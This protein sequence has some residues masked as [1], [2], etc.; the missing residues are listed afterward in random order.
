M[1]EVKHI[2]VF[3]FEGAIRGMR[4]PLSSWDKS[5]SGWV[6]DISGG[7]VKYKYYKIG[8]ADL[9]LMHRLYA[10]GKDGNV[11]HRKFMRQIF[12]CMD[13]T[14]PDYFFKEFSTY[15]VG[16]TENSTS[17][18]HRI[19]AKEFTLDDFSH[20]HLGS[21]G[22]RCLEY[23]ISELNSHRESFLYDKNKDHWWQ[24]I[25]LLPMSYNYTRTITM[26]YENAA[27]MIKQRSG[28]KLDEWNQFVD[29]LLELPYMKQIAENDKVVTRSDKIKSMNDQELARY[30]ITEISDL[31]DLSVD[32][33][34][35][36]LREVQE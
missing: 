17:T 26:N 19:H 32:D 7:S 14:A 23:I 18:M 2:E 8:E 6:H 28:H 20:E 9:G 24:M 34:C 31:S 4:N 29:I 21:S 25:Q 10:A 15:K 30:L 3:N 16:V 5:D 11:A 12:V 13:I 27:N 1:I 35:K 36:W 22:M 33:L